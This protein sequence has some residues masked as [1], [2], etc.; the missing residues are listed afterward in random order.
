MPET[1]KDVS[2]KEK[3]ARMDPEEINKVILNLYQEANESKEVIEARTKALKRI[4]NEQGLELEPFFSP[5][6]F[7]P[8]TERKVY[9]SALTSILWRM[10]MSEEGRKF[11]RNIKRIA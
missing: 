6:A 1:L 2:W 11:F 7:S 4:M 8:N 10:Q 3:F 5:D 9:E